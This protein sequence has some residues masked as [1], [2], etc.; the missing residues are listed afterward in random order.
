MFG[1]NLHHKELF[2]RHRNAPFDGKAQPDFSKYKLDEVG[3]DVTGDQAADSIAAWE[4]LQKKLKMSEDEIRAM[5]PD[6]ELRWHHSGDGQMQLVDKDLHAAFA[7]TGE[8]AIQRALNASALAGIF[9]PNTADLMENGVM[10]GKCD[11]TQAFVAA[12]VD[13]LRMID[14][15]V[16]D[17]VTWTWDAAKQQVEMENKVRDMGGVYIG[18]LP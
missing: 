2:R 11:S 12:G 10:K 15:G 7:H 6:L 3:I 9:A 13:G 16:E 18:W 5:Y 4:K 17:V 14:P 1:N 8:A